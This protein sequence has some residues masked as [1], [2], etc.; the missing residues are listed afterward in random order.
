MNKEELQQEYYRQQQML[1]A[2]GDE[3]KTDQKIVDGH[4][5]GPEADSVRK[6]MADRESEIGRREKEFLSLGSALRAELG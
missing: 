6:R 5:F 4:P 2:L 3:Q 1:K